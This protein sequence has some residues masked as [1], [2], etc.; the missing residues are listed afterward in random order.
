L[1]GGG[2]TEAQYFEMCEQMGWEPREEDI[3][4]DPSTLSLEAQQALVITQ[5][6][7]DK[8]EGMSGAWLGKD[9]SGLG[10]ILDIYEVED[11]RT[12]FELMKI[13]EIEL[14]KFYAQKRKEQES[15]AKAKRGAR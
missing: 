2:I 4:V 5:S 1:Y 3:P 11:K 13:C 14:E 8:W 7:P 6:L 15:L 10:T 9:Y 12:V